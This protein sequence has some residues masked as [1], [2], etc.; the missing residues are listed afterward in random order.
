MGAGAGGGPGYHAA[1]VRYPAAAGLHPGARLPPPA[2]RERVPGPPPAPAPTAPP[3]SPSPVPWPGHPWLRAAKSTTVG[4]DRSKRP[5]LGSARPRL[6][7]FQARLA[8]GSTPP[9]ELDRV[10]VLSRSARCRAEREG[11][12][13]GGWGWGKG[14]TDPFPSSERRESSARMEPSRRGAAHARRVVAATPSPA[15]SPHPPARYARS[16]SERF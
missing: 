9:G 1:R 5:V 7:S 4:A 3:S 15:P 10:R 16:T 13:G 12:A 11:P 14:S 2:R 8:P 6:G